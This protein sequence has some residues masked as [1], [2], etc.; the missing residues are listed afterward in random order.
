MPVGDG[1]KTV[2]AQYND[3]AGNI[4]KAYEQK[5]I[6]NTTAPVIQFTGNKMSYSVD[7]IVNISCIGEDGLSG[8][9][10]S[11]CPAFKGPAY[12]FKI[13]GNTVVASA[14]DKAGNTSSA[15]IH[16]KVTVEFDSLSKL[17]ETFVTKEGVAAGLTS[18]LKAAEAALVKGNR[19]A[20]LGQINAYN[21]QLKAQ[22]SKSIEEQKAQLLISL[23][24]YLK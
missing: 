18:K 14:T 17:T 12:E 10:A 22:T 4:S 19:E 5:I 24:D 11:V 3:H 21:N 9:A 20:I 6:L 2:Y 15:E 8:I 23:V 16:F 7:S 1:E 13:G